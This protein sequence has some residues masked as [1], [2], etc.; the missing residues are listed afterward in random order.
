LFVWSFKIFSVAGEQ[1]LILDKHVHIL[2]KVQKKEVTTLCS[3]EQYNSRSEEVW[4]GY[5]FKTFF[6]GNIFYGKHKH[7][8]YSLLQNLTLLLIQIPTHCAGAQLMTFVMSDSRQTSE[9]MCTCVRTATHT[10]TEG[11]S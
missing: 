5:Y 9:I 7:R 1:T 4:L 8:A 3:F 6:C 10:I 2:P 11:Q